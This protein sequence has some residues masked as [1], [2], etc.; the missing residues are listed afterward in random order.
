MLSHTLICPTRWF[1]LSDRIWLFGQLEPLCRAFAFQ[2]IP[3]DNSFHLKSGL[4]YLRRPQLYGCIRQ[5]GRPDGARCSIRLG[6]NPLIN[7]LIQHTFKLNILF[8][9]KFTVIH[10][11]QKTLFPVNH[12]SPCYTLT[13]VRPQLR[14]RCNNYFTK[15]FFSSK[16]LILS[17]DVPWRRSPPEIAPRWRY[18]LPSNNLTAHYNS[19]V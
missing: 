13:E 2:L 5:C 18:I 3:T 1:Q 10:F 15:T 12:K 11:D 17:T 16:F 4:S 14:K 9:E 6:R 19:F 8:E 7:G